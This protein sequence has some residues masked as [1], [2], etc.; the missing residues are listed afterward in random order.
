MTVKNPK[1]LFLM[2]LSDV[3]ESAERTTKFFQE[4][5]PLVKD[6]EVK[7][8][9]EA[10]LFVANKTNETLDQCFKVIGE[11]PVKLTGRLTEVF[12]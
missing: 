8:A 4:V 10:R 12:V 3:R 9:L 2:L 11:K 7:E 5:I 6:P 1:E